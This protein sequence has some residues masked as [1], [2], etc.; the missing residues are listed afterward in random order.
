MDEPRRTR[1]ERR[2]EWPLTILAVV[3][4]GAYAWPILDPGLPAVTRQGLL[5][6]AW[7]T[8]LTFVVDYIVR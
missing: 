1:W 2:W 3:F 7:L 8:W 4:L 5:W 6:F